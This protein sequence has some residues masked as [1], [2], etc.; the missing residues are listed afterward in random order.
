M[1]AAW[2]EDEALCDSDRDAGGLGLVDVTVG[3]KVTVR[4]GFG[5]IA[6]LE[7]DMDETKGVVSVELDAMAAVR[8]I[9]R[10]CGSTAKVKV[11]LERENVTVADAAE[12]SRRHR[13]ALVDAVGDRRVSCLCRRDFEP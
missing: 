4:C 5:G 2:P 9:Q 8:P 10:W 7:L 11:S 12:F 3:L 13:R 1:V 6:R